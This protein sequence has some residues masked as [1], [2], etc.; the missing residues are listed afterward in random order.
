MPVHASAQQLL[1]R[2]AHLRYDQHVEMR[3][4][5]LRG[6][7]DRNL[8]ITIRWGGYNGGDRPY[9]GPAVKP[10][11]RSIYFNRA[12]RKLVLIGWPHRGG[13]FAEP[14]LLNL[15]NELEEG[16]G[17]V[18]KY[19][20]DNDFFQVLGSF[21]RPES[22][23]GLLRSALDDVESSL[24][25]ELETTRLDVTVAHEQIAIAQYIDTSLPLETT[26][27]YSITETDSIPSLYRTN[28]RN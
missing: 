9:A 22:D 26:T 15:R 27:A 28:P 14:L 7:L 2:N 18:H 16:C 25:A 23:A 11:S 5:N 17:I 6:I 19:P 21:D 10:F 1:S 4:D 20:N 24:Q 8:P 12:T 13:N 3:F